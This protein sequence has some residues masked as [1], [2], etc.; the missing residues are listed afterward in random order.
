MNLYEELKADLKSGTMK[1]TFTKANGETRIMKCTLCEDVIPA[2]KLP[3]GTKNV[4]ESKETIPVFDL[5]ASG[6]R[7]FRVENVISAET[8]FTEN[9]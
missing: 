9:N 1:V 2:E 6:W 7:S 4:T 3:K 8:L 5:E